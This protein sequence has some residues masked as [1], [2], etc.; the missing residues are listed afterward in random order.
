VRGLVG[1]GRLWLLAGVLLI[2]LAGAV[3][4]QEAEEETYLSWTKDFAENAIKAAHE[5]GRVGGF[6]DTRILST[7]R[8]YNYKLSATW[9]TPEVIRAGARIAQL[10]GFLTDEATEE[11][12]ANAEAAGETVVLVEIDPREG[13]GVIPL[14]WGAFLR[15]KEGEDQSTSRIV[16]GVSTPSLRRSPA[17][18]GKLP[19][20]Y[21]YDRFWIVFPLRTPVGQPL[22]DETT[23]DAELVVR[24][25][26]KEGRV[27]WRVPMSIL[28]RISRFPTPLEP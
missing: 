20:N 7:N 13:S 1:C 24:I 14:E 2:V 19:R 5:D 26:G 21:D 17:L 11:L 12:L 8:S 18:A 25:S 4:A 10:N 16:R 23:S 27:S 22:F 15:P 3:S 6:F 9:L 28:T